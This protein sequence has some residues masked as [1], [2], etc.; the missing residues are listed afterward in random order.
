M[1]LFKNLFDYETKELKRI[2]KIVDSIE[3]LDEDMQK[4]K[5]KD[6]AKKTEEF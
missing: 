3:A 5:D 1:G 2:D 4:L 6:F